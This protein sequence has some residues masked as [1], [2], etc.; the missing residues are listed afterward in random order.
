MFK[1]YNSFNVL[2]L[3]KWEHMSTINT[4]LCLLCAS[5]PPPSSTPVPFPSRERPE[6]HL[7]RIQRERIPRREGNHRC[8]ANGEARAAVKSAST[9]RRRPRLSWTFQNLLLA[10]SGGIS[11]DLSPSQL[12][13]LI[14]CCTRSRRLRLRC[15]L[16]PAAA[17]QEPRIRCERFY[18]AQWYGLR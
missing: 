13:M 16:D 10:M 9:G 6:A 17:L 8:S 7:V 4:C 11:V 3:K 18:K 5:S 15:L 2:I 14:H 1:K 12:P